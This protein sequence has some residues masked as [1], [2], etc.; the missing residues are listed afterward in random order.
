M[1]SR[2]LER[3]EHKLVW[4]H[5]V[6]LRDLWSQYEYL[7]MQGP[8][9]VALL[10]GSARWF[11]YS[12]QKSYETELVLGISRL[13]DPPGE[14][15][16]ANLTIAVILDDP[17]VEAAGDLRKDL[18]SAIKEAKDAAEI[19]RVHRNKRL[20]HLDRD[21]ASGKADSLPA[22]KL[23]A[24]GAALGHLERAYHRYGL[25]IEGPTTSLS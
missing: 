21:V 14:G 17:Q 5:L 2:P 18:E 4:D 25:E 19:L 3:E 12:V 1:S 16:R 7:F 10:N 6:L 8:E 24:F 9:R 13:T 20:A 22:L 23:S 15:S 11:F